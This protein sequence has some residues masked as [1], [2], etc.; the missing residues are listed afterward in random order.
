[1]AYATYSDLEDRF[2]TNVIK[3]AHISERKLAKLSVSAK[4]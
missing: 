4:Q 2:D 1:M 3:D